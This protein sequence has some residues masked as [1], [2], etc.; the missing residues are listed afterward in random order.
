MTN[1]IDRPGEVDAEID[2]L[3]DRFLAEGDPNSQ[4]EAAQELIKDPH[5]FPALQPAAV[6]LTR[7]AE[8]ASH[9]S[10][11]SLVKTAT[12]VMMKY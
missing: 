11:T 8:D 4:Y 6:E 10:I 5:C 2:M 9:E 3:K 1:A 12:P 7:I